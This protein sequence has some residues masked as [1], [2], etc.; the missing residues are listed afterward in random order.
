M[1]MNAWKKNVWSG[2]QNNEG[3]DKNKLHRKTSRSSNIV[4]FKNIT[5]LTGSEMGGKSLYW[6]LTKSFYT[7]FIGFAKTETSR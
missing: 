2:Y 3:N 4:V 6:L 1:D 7:S 5:S